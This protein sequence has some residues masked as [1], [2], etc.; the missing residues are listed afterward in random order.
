MRP[1][2]FGNANFLDYLA[3]FYRFFAGSLRLTF[4]TQVNSAGAA[5]SSTYIGYNSDVPSDIVSGTTVPIWPCVEAFQ[6]AQAQVPTVVEGPVT[7]AVPYQ[8]QFHQMPVTTPTEDLN[9]QL[10]FV[11]ASVGYF[12]YGTAVIQTQNVQAYRG[13][14]DDFSF[15]YLVGC[16]W[17][18]W[19]PFESPSELTKG[20]ESLEAS[21]VTPATTL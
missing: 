5:F 6:V 18:I 11:R 19:H 21:A 7:V 2:Q 20:S 12:P 8:S 10:Y 9:G 15:G 1:Y 13:A 17:G 16:P 14:G 4:S 3:N